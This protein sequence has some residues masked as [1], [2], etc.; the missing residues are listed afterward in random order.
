MAVPAA[1][2]FRLDGSTAM[3]SLLG[4]AKD[5]VRNLCVRRHSVQRRRGRRVRV[6]KFTVLG[7]E[8]DYPLGGLHRIPPA[9]GPARFDFTAET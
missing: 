2:R 5:P 1:C 8:E 6:A 4:I 9:A 7:P 3:P